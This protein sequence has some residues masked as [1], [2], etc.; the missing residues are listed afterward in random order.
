MDITDPASVEAAILRL[1]PWAIIN[2]CGYVRVDDAEHE[3]ER[4][5]RENTVGPNILA[6]AS[7]RH[8]LRFMTFSSDLVFDGKLGRSYV[9]SDPVAPLGV[10]GR[11]KAEAEQRVLAAD[12]QALVVRSS[13][14]FGPWDAHNFVTRALN[15]LDA[16]Q[17]FMAAN[18]LVVSPTYVPDLVNTC[19]DLLIDG[20][21]GI[22][23]LTNSE[24]VTW[25]ELARRACAAAGVDSARLATPPS[26]ELGLAAARPA[27]SALHSERA[28]LLPPLD[29]ALERMAKALAE[30]AN[31]PAARRIIERTR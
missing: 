15:A 8:A 29:D 9:E 22:W 25:A 11:S 6:L 14:F 27:N 21:R 13:A 7:I 5:M 23:H 31:D 2:A 28:V 19:L 18:D 20:E 4:C 3:P 24:P 17:P 26:A 30:R 12:P 1:K 10:Y 16:G